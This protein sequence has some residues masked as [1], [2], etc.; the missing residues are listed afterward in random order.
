MS[1]MK[2]TKTTMFKLN[3]TTL[4]YMRVFQDSLHLVLSHSH[5]WK[6]IIKVFEVNIVLFT[7]LII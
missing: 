3:G 5:W 2:K 7:P 1:K 4:R 6:Y